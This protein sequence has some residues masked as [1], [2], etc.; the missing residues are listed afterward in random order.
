MVASP[1]LDEKTFPVHVVT[2]EF[3]LK[4]ELR[5]RG[6]LD[7]LLNGEDITTVSLFEVQAQ[8]LDPGNVAAQFAAPKVVLARRACQFI[9]FSERPSGDDVMIKA[10]L[11]AA[12]LYTPRFAIRGSVH[13]GGERTVTDVLGDIKGYFLPVADAELFP[14]FR[15][16]ANLPRQSPLVLVYRDHAEIIQER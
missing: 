16:R 1:H 4:G 5:V 10:N 13:L 2:G 14:L 12:V 9:V 8:A 7:T 6:V 15:I 3:L 11:R